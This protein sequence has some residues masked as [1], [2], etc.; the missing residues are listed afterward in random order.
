MCGQEQEKDNDC[1]GILPKK[2]EDKPKCVEVH[3]DS[4]Q[5]I[6]NDTDKD[7]GWKISQLPLQYAH[8]HESSLGIRG[9]DESAE[10][11]CRTVQAVSDT[12]TQTNADPDSHARA[13]EETNKGSSRHFRCYLGP[14]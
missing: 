7:L 4:I 5:S 12:S 14:I 11:I 10:W 9:R 1:K 6:A 13:P 3:A 8:R 2:T